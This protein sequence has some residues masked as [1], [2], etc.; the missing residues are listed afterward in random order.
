MFEHVVDAHYAVMV[1]VV[2][3]NRCVL[4]DG[5]EGHENVLHIHRLSC[6][7]AV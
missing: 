4:I 7:I 2:W 6:K 5:K 3:Q 1:A